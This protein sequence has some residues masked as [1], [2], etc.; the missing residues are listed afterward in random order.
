MVFKFGFVVLIGCFNVGKFIFMNY[1]VGKKI[2][3]ILFKL[4]IIRNSIKGIFIL[5]DV[6]IIFI[7][8]SG[9]YFLKNKLGE[10]MVK[11]FEKILKEVDLILYIVEVID[12]GIGLWDEVIIEKLKEV[13]ILKILVLNKFDFVLKEN[14]EILKSIFFIK[15]NFEFIVDIAV[16]NG[17]NCDLFFSKI[18]ELFLE[19]LKYYFDDMIID[20]R[21]S[22]I[23]VEIIREKILFNFFEEVLYGVGIVIERF[24]ERENKDI[25]DIEVIIYCEKDLYKVIIIGKGGQMFKK[26]GM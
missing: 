21:E 15:L 16:I 2:F 7:D 11:V 4:Q 12:N 22:F 23:V 3:I 26:I 14:I 10:Y 6:Q 8:I 9:V 13:E 25:L 18:K 17:Y 19:G 20:V 5:E 24:V 1:F